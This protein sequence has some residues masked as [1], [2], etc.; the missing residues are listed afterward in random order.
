MLDAGPPGKSNPEDI[1]GKL[2]VLALVINKLLIKLVLVALPAKEIPK[3]P[4]GKVG[5]SISTYIG[6]DILR[7]L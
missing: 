1:T 3:D 7:L 6:N 5:T 4:I 2:G